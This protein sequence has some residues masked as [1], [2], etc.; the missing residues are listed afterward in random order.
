MPTKCEKTWIQILRVIHNK[1]RL[2]A[3][4]RNIQYM[5]LYPVPIDFKTSSFCNIQNLK[6]QVFATFA[7]KS[8][9]HFV[10]FVCNESFEV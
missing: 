10:M 8:M 4:K 1:T 7:Q 9:M 3:L 5:Y 2:D 6:Y